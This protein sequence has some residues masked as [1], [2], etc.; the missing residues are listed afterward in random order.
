M[1]TIRISGL[2]RAMRRVQEHLGAG[3]LPEQAEAFRR[4]VRQLTAQVETICREQHIRPEDLPTPS[5]RA[6]RFLKDLDLNALPLRQSA[7]SAPATGPRPAPPVVR[8]TNVVSAQAQMN[9][10]FAEWTAVAANRDVTLTAAHPVCKPFSLLLQNHVAEIETLAREQGGGPGQLPTQSRRAYQWL[11]FLSDADNLAAHLETLR[12]LQAE[13][14]HPRCRMRV[15][16]ERRQLAVVEFGYTTHLYRVQVEPEG[17]RVTLHEGFIGAP[18]TLLR[19]LACAVLL[20]DREAHQ[21]AVKEYANSDEFQEV[22]TDLELTTAEMA[23]MTRGRCFDL[24]VI[25]AR[26]NAAYFAGQMPRPR[27]TWNQ[28]VT[29]RKLGHYDYVRDVVMLSV[30]LDAPEV[31]EYMVDFVM[32]HELLH[33][34]LGVNVVNGRRYAHTPEFR[35]AERRFRQY[36]QAQAFLKRPPPAGKKPRGG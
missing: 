7:V 26:V 19:D 25:F 17:L 16:P 2:V 10:L 18:A 34:Q 8:I 22:V 1:N 35:E 20:N 3:I 13:L 27:L 21:Q 24:E 12:T 9:A 30:T 11:K 31:P 4:E 5:Y 33:K 15:A 36:E 32:Y 6:Y 14:H 23:T 28:I 29:Q